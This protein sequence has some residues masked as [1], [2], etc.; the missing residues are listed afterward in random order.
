MD[1]ALY[2]LRDEYDKYAAECECGLRTVFARLKN[3]SREM[4]LSDK[5]SPFA[6][7]EYR[8]KDF[9]SAIEKCKRRG[10]ENDINT[11]KR[12]MKDIAGI[13]IIVPY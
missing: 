12:E 11:I 6:S 3:L 8:L 9:D 4:E 2:S 7:I 1:V 5:R 13:R 10:W